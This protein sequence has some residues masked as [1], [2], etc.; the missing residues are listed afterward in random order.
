MCAKG[1]G[2]QARYVF[3]VVE[4]QSRRVGLLELGR[5][6]ALVVQEWIPEGGSLR[7]VSI[8]LQRS[9]HSKQSRIDMAFV[10]DSTPLFFQH[11]EGPDLARAVKSTWQRQASQYLGESLPGDVVPARRK[12]PGGEEQRR[13]A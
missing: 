9:S 5:G 2:T 3:S 4:W 10:S 1:L 13:T 6:H 11:I 7:G 8:E 12:S